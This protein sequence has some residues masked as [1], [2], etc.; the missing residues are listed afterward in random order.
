MKNVLGALRTD[1]LKI[2]LTLNQLKIGK[3]LNSTKIVYVHA[4]LCPYL[5]E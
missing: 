4:L 2:S 5:E 1:E 3:N